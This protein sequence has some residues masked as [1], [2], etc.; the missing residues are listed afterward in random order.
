[1]LSITPCKKLNA[2]AYKSIRQHDRLVRQGIKRGLNDSK[3]DIKDEAKRLMDEAKHGAVY[4]VYWSKTGRRLSKPR[5][6]TASR[7]NEPFALMSGR[8]YRSIDFQIN[9]MKMRVGFGTEWG[10][11]WERTKRRVL[12]TAITKKRREIVQNMEREIQR[13]IYKFKRAKG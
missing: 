2:P 5:K 3:E 7:Y 8:T 12:I 9:A 6:H 13:S 1:M 10:A 11:F 4:D